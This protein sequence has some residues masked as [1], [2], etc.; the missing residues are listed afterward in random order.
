MAA[1]P[2]T[3]PYCGVGCGVLAEKSADRVAA[4]SGDVLHPANKGKLCSKGTHLGETIGL[5]GRLLH[6]EIT[7]DKASWEQ[8]LDLVADRFS[9]AIKE[10]GPDSVAFYVSGQLLTEDYYVA[11][12]LMKGLVGSGNIDTNSRLCMASAVAAHV[13]SFGEDIVPGCY[14]DIDEADVIILVGSNTAW[15]HPV[16]YQRIMRAKELRGCKIIVIDPRRTETAETADLHLP[17][18]S[19]TDVALFQALLAHMQHQNSLDHAYLKHVSVPDDFWKQLWSLGDPQAYAAQTCMLDPDAVALFFNIFLTHKKTMTIFSQ[20]VNQ[21][22]SGTDKAT[23]ILNLHLATGRMGKPGSTAFSITGQPNA[24]GGREVGGLATSLAAHMDFSPAHVER[25]QKFWGFP[26]VASK[27]GLKAVDL[28]QAMHT[29]KIKAVWIMATNPAASMPDTENVRAALA[30]CP[31]VVV[32]DC[33]AQTDTTKF[34]DVLLPSAAWGEKDG[35]VTNSERMISRQ[36]SFLDMP[37]DAKADWWQLAQVG[38]RLAMLLDKKN[39]F[40][41]DS[42]ASIF[43]EHAALSGFENTKGLSL[44]LFNIGHHAQLSDAEYAALAPFQW[45]EKRYFPNGEFPTADRRARLVPIGY[46]PPAGLVN[47]DF[48]HALNTGRLRDQW[49]TMTRTGLS[50]SL[51]RHRPEP[52]VE[53]APADAALLGLVSGDLAGLTTTQGT[54]IFRVLVTDVQQPGDIFI[55]IHWTGSHSNGGRA[56]TLVSAVTDPLSG[57]PEFKHTPARVVKYQPAFYGLLIATNLP[58]LSRLDYWTRIFSHEGQAAEFSSNLS[59]EALFSLLL[60]QSVTMNRLDMHDAQRGIYRTIAL[61]DGQCVAALY[62]SSR[63]ITLSR[64]WLFAAFG[65]TATPALS[66]LA[67]QSA[68]LQNDPGETVCSCFNV[69][70]NTIRHCIRSEKPFHIDD[71]GKSLQAGTNCGSCRPALAKLL[72]EEIMADA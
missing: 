36:R 34:A 38:Q 33:M 17:L 45:G 46:Q 43:R 63:P 68:G 31:F 47:T 67:G 57:Q 21:S 16:V 22:S 44:R 24:M 28:F 4:I 2:T 39:G 37:G 30:Q 9:A 25:V 14:D 56:G 64:N 62:L 55:P 48:P 11:N 7:G 8:A 60:P 59:A 32:S 65:D 41:F 13:R 58:D 10:F 53:I 29:G 66:L 71:I 27:P 42:A 35:T 18:K 49:H 20:G 61:Q 3:C 40:N 15:C 5:T 50:A 69:G 12:K 54:Q 1:I 23:S 72:K 52:A 51:S 6:P 70:A 19:G 26:N